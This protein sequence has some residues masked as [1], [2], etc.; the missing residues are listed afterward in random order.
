[1]SAS[2]SGGPLATYETEVKKNNGAVSFQNV[3]A[4]RLLNATG[5]IGSVSMSGLASLS[6]TDTVELWI[7]QTGGA[8]ASPVLRDVTLSVSEIGR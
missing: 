5:D 2:Y 6:A 4:E 1:M 8:L 3:H 7:R